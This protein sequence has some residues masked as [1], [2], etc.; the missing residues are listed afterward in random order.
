MPLRSFWERYEM[1][2]VIAALAFLLLVR[3]VTAAQTP[4]AA[5]LDTIQH[6]AFNYFW[7][8]ANPYRLCQAAP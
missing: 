3:D 4:I 7:Y 8:Q 2:R 1:K 5:I 6:T